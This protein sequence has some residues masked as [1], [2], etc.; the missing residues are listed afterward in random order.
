MAI[1]GYVRSSLHG[2]SVEM[3]LRQ[4]EEH[5][6]DRIF[7]ETIIGAAAHLLRRHALL[8]ILKEGDTV[9]VCSLDRIARNIVDLSEIIEALENRGVTYQVLDIGLDSVTASGRNML[10][11]LKALFQFQ[12]IMKRERRV[13]KLNSPC[14]PLPIKKGT[15]EIKFLQEKGLSR[16]EIAA[17]LK[18][19]VTKFDDLVFSQVKDNPWQL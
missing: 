15:A 7:E 18:I 4:L 14:I 10:T 11:M 12:K 1:V 8:K 16:T 9:V 19:D 6:I 3:Q 2:Q 13:E 17:R 5:G